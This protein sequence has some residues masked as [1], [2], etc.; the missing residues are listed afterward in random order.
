[1]D[2]VLGT[3]NALVDIVL[4]L[5]NDLVLEKFGLPKGS[6]QLV[7]IDMANKV[8][9]IKQSKNNESRMLPINDTL[10]S[11]LKP[12]EN[13]SKEHYVFANKNGNAYGEVRR[14]FSTALKKAGINNFHFHDLR[15]TF[16]SRLVMSG[17]DIRTVQELM[18][19]KDIR[20]TMRYS[21]LS[22]AH[23]K[24]AVNKLGGDIS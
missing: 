14:S 24:D 20:M 21:H 22:D 11:I 5:Q 23:L 6:M 7:D 19:H 16:A 15:H 4:I 9:T 10:F 8:I 12:M 2:T 17:V 3:G 13:S 1:M 18:G